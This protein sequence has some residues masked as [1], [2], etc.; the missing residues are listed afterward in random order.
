MRARAVILVMYI[1]LLVL[2]L[3]VGSAYPVPRD[4]ALPG[5]ATS[6]GPQGG[7]APMSP[8]E[9]D[10]TP[11]FKENI[12]QYGEGGG[13]FVYSTTGCIVM[14]DASTVTYCVPTYQTG[15]WITEVVTLEFIGSND[16]DPVGKGIVTHST[17][18]LLG[19]DPGRWYIGVASY[20]TLVYHN[21]YDGIDLVYFFDTMM[22]KYEFVVGA[23]IDPGMI[24]IKYA[25][26]DRLELDDVNGDLIIHAGEAEIRD[27]APIAYLPSE[28]EQTQV[29]CSFDVLDQNIVGFAISAYDTGS[30]LVIDPTLIF[31]TLLGG[32]GY[33][34]GIDITVDPSG[35]SYV[36]GYTKNSLFDITPGALD[37][38]YNLGTDVFVSK[39]SK[40]GSR[41]LY[42]TFI[43]GGDYD[44]GLGI[45]LDDEGNIYVG[46]LTNSSDFP[47]TTG[48]FDETANGDMDLFLLKIDPTGTK[49]EFSSLVGGSDA[50]LFRGLDVDD[51]G[52]VYASGETNSSD[53]PTTNGTFDETHNGDFDIFL[54]KMEAN[55][56]SLVYSTFVGDVGADIGAGV[57]VDGSGNSYVAGYTNSTSFPTTAGAYDRSHD[58]HN[59]VFAFKMN[60]AGT[61]LVYSTF[62]G[63]GYG[64]YCYDLFLGRN[65]SLYMTG[66]T[67][68]G[69]PTTPDAYDST[70]SFY[71][72]FIT[73]LD[74]WGSNLEMSTLVGAGSY[75]R[76]YGICADGAGRVYVTG[77]V[78]S[79]AFPTTSDAYNR[80]HSGDADCF[81][82]RM[83]ANGSILDY[84]TFLG[85]D[86]SDYGNSI[87]LDLEGNV[88]VTGL[89]W[90]PKDFPYTPGAY[91]KGVFPDFRQVFVAKFGSFDEDGPV[92]EAD[93]TNSLAIAGEDLVFNVSISDDFGIANASVE[94]W[95]GSS[96]KH[97]NTSLDLTGGDRS[98]GGWGKSLPIPEDMF[99]VVNYYVQV[100][101]T[102]GNVARGPPMVVRVRENLPPSVSDD[103]SGNATTG[104]EFDL[105]VTGY[106]N[107]GI[108]Q[109]HVVFWF[110]Q[111]VDKAVNATMVGVNTSGR[112][113]GTYR[114]TV[115]IP[116]DSTATLHYY[117]ELVDLFG[118]WNRTDQISVEVT[119]DDRP[120]L[121]SDLTSKVATTG[122]AF[123]FS[124][125]VNDNIGLASVHVV[126][127]FGTNV[128]GHVNSSMKGVETSGMGNGTYSL[129]IVI[130]G[131]SIDI[132]HYRFHLMDVNGNLML[133]EITSV[134]PSDNDLPVIVT[135]ASD[136]LAST[137]EDFGFSVDVGDNIAVTSV[138]LEYWFGD[139]TSVH[140][141]M[142]P[143]D[144]DDRGNGTYEWRIA[145]PSDERDPLRYRLSLSDEA[146]NVLTS[147]VVSLEVIDNDLPWF[148]EDLS[149]SSGLKGLN[150]TLEMSANDN[151]GYPIAFVEYWY[152]GGHAVNA[153]MTWD[154][155]YK[156]EVP[157]PRDAVGP[158]FYRY[159]F[160]DYSHNWNS[161][162]V[163]S[164]DLRNDPPKFVTTP[165]WDV[166]EESDEVLDLSEYI[167]DSNDPYSALSITVEDS[168]FEVDG[169]E[170]R[171]RI[172]DWIPDFTLRILLSDGEDQVEANITV[173]V[174]NVNDPPR[175]IKI[176]APTN[177]T[178]FAYKDPVLLDV[179]FEDADMA[180]GETVYITWSSDKTG[181]LATYT[182]DNGTSFTLDSMKPGKHVIKVTVSDGEESIDAMVEIRI[183]KKDESPG[184]TIP[185]VLVCLILVLIVYRIKRVVTR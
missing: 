17:N 134:D 180:A 58:D 37:V 100:E 93:N 151:A 125:R 98:S 116:G 131:D 175:D 54:L 140:V 8:T 167:E 18:Y 160:R 88:L 55:G 24:R 70:A 14:F 141:E 64:D 105:S 41:L 154:T 144:V 161:S 52:Y 103:T 86:S 111:A 59:D 152:D 162:D 63:G 109:V 31:S 85:T 119:D 83:S 185:I 101:D 158:L 46:G 182:S 169:L 20:K 1:V 10:T 114:Y 84:G 44:E 45:R 153:S 113:N 4:G 75:E 25:G 77:Y 104:D 133:A 95:Y 129:Q 73:K 5:V 142:D 26:P 62:I 68:H 127:W 12:G 168:R 81:V 130:P 99:E 66:M 76:G 183:E 159:S 42:S 170:L 150:V 138:R 80:T 57:E 16:V 106:D 171:V 82:L 3:P 177:G 34:E 22:L 155:S 71:D 165:N 92:I 60:P 179:E 145:V 139:G 135:D 143:A 15:V 120:A 27:Q 13:Q 97:Q 117:I 79:P 90:K 28:E 72:V 126:Y 87:A 6:L 176:I 96:S 149:P 7:I 102:S 53:F 123:I 172:D 136:N 48:A 174:T 137:G 148:I 181:L 78:R 107:S 156:V 157:V 163:M 50:D 29:A 67:G 112:G 9:T 74:P 122:D 43:G 49:L 164:M 61:N 108:S 56:S 118:N 51:N 32:P 35:C 39:F 21:L 40:D 65:G 33:E 184:P 128:D 30:V 147:E 36:T 89:T 166:L 38:S 124:A 110:G 11:C 178:K 121:E 115:S 47:T 23:G 19:S 2:V 146:G 173:S 94:Y 69:Y 91:E 132:L